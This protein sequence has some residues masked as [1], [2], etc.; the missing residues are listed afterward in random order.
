MTELSSEQEELRLR[1]ARIARLMDSSIRIPI[2]GKTIGWEAIIG[3][4]P[5]IGDVAGGLVSAYI[6]IAARRLGASWGV[7]MR[8]LG[9]VGLE[10]VVGTV[11]VIGDLFDMAFKANLR[12]VALLETY[13]DDRESQSTADV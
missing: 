7:V 10:V 1:I 8:M 6:V 11:P 2:I 4:I 5:G 12:N 3:L 13:L 9:N